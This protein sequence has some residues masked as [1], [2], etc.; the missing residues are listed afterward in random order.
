MIR[1]FKYDIAISVAEE[2]KHVADQ[3]AAALKKLGIRYYYYAENEI[4][5]W[6]SHIIDLTIDAYGRQARF[7]LMITSATFVNKYWSGL[8]KLIALAKT[9]MG[10]PHILQLRL[11]NTPIDGISKHVVYQDWKNNPEHIARMLKEKIRGQRRTRQRKTGITTAGISSSLAV[12]SGLYLLF[13]P[14][15]IKKLFP[16]K[17]MQRMLIAGPGVDSFY[18]SNTEVTIDEYSTYC[19]SVGKQVPPQASGLKGD[20]PIANITWQEA[21]DFC[22]AQN[23]RLPTER[24]WEYAADAGLGKKYSGG[25]NAQKVAIY[26]TKRPATVAYLEPNTFN[27]YDMTGNIA[28][29]CADWSDSL[30]RF[31]IVKGGSYSSR[32]SPENELLI[33]T[34][35]IAN[36]EERCPDIGFRVAWNKQ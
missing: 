23:G 35:I 20:A 15:L 12:L 2:D 28:E 9:R 13:N 26:N 29:W 16:V 21:V 6:G 1:L 4:G 30:H 19:K 32:I 34:R 25:N 36:P 8:E 5:S 27:L 14:A 3:I 11:D 7:V 24:E 31:K 22:K 33:S 10:E 18:I 17:H